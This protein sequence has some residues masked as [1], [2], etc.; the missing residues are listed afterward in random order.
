MKNK[1]VYSRQQWLQKVHCF[2]LSQACSFFFL[3]IFATVNRRLISRFSIDIM[4]NYQRCAIF[5][6]C[7]WHISKIRIVGS[8]QNPLLCLWRQFVLLT[9]VCFSKKK[10]QKNRTTQTLLL[11]MWL[12]G[13]NSL[14]IQKCTQ[15]Q[16]TVLKTVHREWDCVSHHLFYIKNE[17]AQRYCSSN[18][19]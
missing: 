14:K 2:R 5:S 16:L 8:I 10:K 17:P 4:N 12:C 3:G 19:R 18:S 11:Q 6:W 15:Q 1:P 9:F 7:G 13:R